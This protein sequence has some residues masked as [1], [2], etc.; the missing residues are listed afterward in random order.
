MRTLLG[1]LKT[2]KNVDTEQIREEFRVLHGFP[3]IQERNHLLNQ[4]FWRFALNSYSS[5]AA[6]NENY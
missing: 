5:R 4:C 3:T 1:F 6:L 2:P